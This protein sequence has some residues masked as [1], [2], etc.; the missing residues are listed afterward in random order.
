M[1]QFQEN[2]RT[3]R[4]TEEWKDIQLVF[5]CSNLT[6]ETPGECAKSVQS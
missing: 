2:A 1:I 5:S 3:D 6:M 4:K